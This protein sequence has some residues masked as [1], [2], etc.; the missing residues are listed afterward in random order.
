[1]AVLVNASS[2]WMLILWGVI[3]GIGASGI[4]LLPSLAWGTYFGRTFL[5][6][7]RGITSPVAFFGQAVGPLFAAFLYDEL[8]SYQVPYSV[9]IGLFLLSAALMLF[10]RKPVPP[11]PEPIPES[12]RLFPKDAVE[13][14]SG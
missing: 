13:S 11:A 2:L 4:S 14:V 6:S 10:A 9:F 5:G 7:I 12:Q 8:G 1:M 3:Y